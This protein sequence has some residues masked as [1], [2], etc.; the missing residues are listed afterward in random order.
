MV[1]T[2]NT[3][4]ADK[5]RADFS[6]SNNGNKAHSKNTNKMTTRGNQLYNKQKGNED[7][8]YNL[9]NKTDTQDTS[10]DIGSTLDVLGQS[11]EVRDNENNEEECL[12]DNEEE[13]SDVSSNNGNPDDNQK[14]SGED[15]DEE[16]ENDEQDYL[17]PELK[18]YVRQ[19]IKRQDKVTMI[20]NRS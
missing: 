18:Q 16:K 9:Q 6:R 14:D 15:E 19:N 11:I 10:F 4:S 17:N 2:R 20:V 7:F 3:K 8:V 12:N 13:Y 5:S 1:T